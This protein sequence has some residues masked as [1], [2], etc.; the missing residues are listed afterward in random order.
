[1]VSMLNTSD[2]E[3]A[4]NKSSYAANNYDDEVSLRELISV[5][6]DG[7]YTV[8]AFSL[9]FAFSSILYSLWQPNVYRAD[10]LL[11]AS[12]EESSSGLAALAGEYAGLATLAGLE[13]NSG[14]SEVDKTIAILKSRSFLEEFINKHDLL[15]LLF[16]L[17]QGNYFSRDP[18][19]DGNIYDEKAGA[20][21]GKKPSIWQARRKLST[22]LTITQNKKIGLITLAI[23]WY[24]PEQAR[25][26]VEWLVE[27]VNSRIKV[28]DVENAR[29]SVDYLKESLK[30]TS[31][32]EFKE[33]FYS[34][35]ETQMKT[36][37]LA[38]IRD[39]YALMTID[40]AVVPEE[41]VGPK[42]FFICVVGTMLGVMCGF[43][44]VF[45]RFYLPKIWM[46]ETGQSSL[47]DSQE[48]VSLRG[49][50]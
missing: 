12:S 26:W 32:V 6:W 14:G 16:A 15:I 46:P 4:V 5:V 25:Q 10:A 43:I 21:I 45:L 49:M 23:E 34:L 38:E 44:W 50:E 13:L 8:I 41:K 18:E 3:R 36:I 1:M 35:I 19:I 42:R 29:K 20:W 30:K 2:D 17:K 22:H 37:M 33:V 48:P 28:N 27:D 40:P 7:K 24:D 39:E 31:I 47:D 9:V 11:A